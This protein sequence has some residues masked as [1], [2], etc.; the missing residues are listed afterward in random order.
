MSVNIPE[1][2]KKAIGGVPAVVKAAQAIVIASQ[3]DLD[4][5]A[6]DLKAIVTRRKELE[7]KRVAITKPMDAAK[8]EVMD[9]FR[10]PVDNL[11]QA[12]AL[13]KKEIGDYSAE[14]EKIRQAELQAARE[15]EEKERRER[16]AEAQ[17]A[18][19]AKEI[20]DRKLAEAQAIKD[21]NMRKAAAQKREREK[22]EAEEDRL[23]KEAE[24]AEQA[25]QDATSE[26]D[27]ATYNAMTVKSATAATEEAKTSGVSTRTV[28]KA[29]VF[30]VKALIR[31]VAEGRVS[32]NVINVD[33]SVLDKMATQNKDALNVP[34]VRA[35]SSSSVSVRT[36]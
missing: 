15:A 2:T 34:G 19:D 30:D 5:A 10:D 9:L 23:K 21:G 24:E 3:S 33:Q 6:V 13:I 12:E 7:A 32:Q 26:S 1:E 18:E 28:W 20:E 25:T 17:K 4:N 29:E 36:K 11:K 14:Q 27:E 8:K 35:V 31:A 16:E 22:A